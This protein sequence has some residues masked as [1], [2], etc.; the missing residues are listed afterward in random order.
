MKA[1][2][3]AVSEQIT[4]HAEE[5]SGIVFHVD[6]DDQVDI[7]GEDTID[8]RPKFEAKIGYE[9][10]KIWSK[11]EVNIDSIEDLHRFVSIYRTLSMYETDVTLRFFSEQVI[12]ETFSKTYRN[13]VCTKVLSCVEESARERGERFKEGVT[14]E[15]GHI[16]T[17]QAHSENIEAW[18]SYVASEK[19]HVEALIHSKC[20]QIKQDDVDVIA[21]TH[22]KDI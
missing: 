17:A 1:L 6:H 14:Q 3:D 10:G 13:F 15:N 18:V 22:G 9:D 16:M 21:R 8:K 12:D 20:V 11:L 7:F 19:P 5:L 2:V 4:H